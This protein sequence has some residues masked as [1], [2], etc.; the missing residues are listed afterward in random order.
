MIQNQGHQNPKRPQQSTVFTAAFRETLPPREY[1][2]AS[3]LRSSVSSPTLDFAHTF[4]FKFVFI[5]YITELSFILNCLFIFFQYSLVILFFCSVYISGGETR[6]SLH[7]TTRWT[8]YDCVCYE[9]SSLDF[10]FW[11]ILGELLFNCSSLHL[12]K[13]KKSILLNVLSA[14]LCLWSRNIKVDILCFIPPTTHH[15]KPPIC[16]CSFLTN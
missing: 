3:F 16:Y 11:F 10:E 8:M 1:G 4:H 9:W 7:F 13:N 14:G 5:F 6:C 2:R 12:K 15:S